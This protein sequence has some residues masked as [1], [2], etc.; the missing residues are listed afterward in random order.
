MLK[1]MNVSKT[2]KLFGYLDLLFYQIAMAKDNGNQLMASQF[3]TNFDQIDLQII[4]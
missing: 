2:G 3:V 4:L 1:N